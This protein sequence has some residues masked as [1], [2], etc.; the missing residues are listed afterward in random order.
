MKIGDLIKWTD[1]KGPEPIEHVGLFIE[2]L[3]NF[4]VDAVDSSWGDIIVIYDGE[5]TKWTSWQCEVISEAA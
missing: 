2:K 3:E 5:Y 1:Y 4:H